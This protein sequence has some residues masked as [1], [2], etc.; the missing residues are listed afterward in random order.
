MIFV[1]L[2]MLKMSA[3]QMGSVEDGGSL[4]LGLL[5]SALE[6]APNTATPYDAPAEMKERLKQ[7]A[8]DFESTGEIPKVAPRLP[9]EGDSCPICYEDLLDDTA[10]VHCGYGCG[11][12]VHD[13]CFN[14]YRAAHQQSRV[15]NGE[16]KCVT[17]RTNWVMEARTIGK[18]GLL[19]GRRAVN[20]AEEM[21]EAFSPDS[22][23]L[24]ARARNSKAPR[25]K[26]SR[27]RG[28][29]STRGRSTAGRSKA[30]AS[31]R[32][33]AASSSNTPAVRGGR[34]GKNG[35]RGTRKS[36]RLSRGS[37]SGGASS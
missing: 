27:G 17:C 10:L 3:E 28:G 19:V 12:P 35:R 31:S 18:R 1:C 26:A 24:L 9:E 23:P 37:G 16:L 29:R 5:H 11:K 32:R 13:E 14:R 2:R 25:S 20:L 8:G 4:D 7:I 21:P 36:A 22:P 33:G 6:K 15:P 30:P 34:V